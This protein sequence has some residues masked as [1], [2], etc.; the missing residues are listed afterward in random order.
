MPRCWTRWS[1][2]GIFLP[3]TFFEPGT[4]CE[5]NMESEKMYV[6]LW[7]SNRYLRYL[8]IHILWYLVIRVPKPQGARSPALSHPATNRWH[9][10]RHETARD[11]NGS[12]PPWCLGP[13]DHRG[14]LRTSVHHPRSQCS[15]PRRGKTYKRHQKHTK[16]RNTDLHGIIFIYFT[17]HG[18]VTA[19]EPF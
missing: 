16:T 14:V 4:F 15:M 11:Q 8:S 9:P 7:I 13:I 17:V 18:S 5:Q 10:K 19:Q 6:F 3:S 1:W 2:C 12:T